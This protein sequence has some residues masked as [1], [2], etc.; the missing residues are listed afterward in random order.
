MGRRSTRATDVWPGLT[1][2][3]P[4]RAALERRRRGEVMPG[5]TSRR[6]VARRRVWPASALPPPGLRFAAAPATHD[7]RSLRRSVAGADQREAPARVS[8]TSLA[9]CGG[10]T[11]VTALQP[12]ATLRTFCIPADEVGIL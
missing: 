5:Q 9:L 11:H 2:G 12:G 6:T 4:R 8:A 1:N 3:K 7:R 10:S